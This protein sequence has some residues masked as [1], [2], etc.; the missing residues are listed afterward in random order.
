MSVILGSL[1]G[2]SGADLLS[3]LLSSASVLSPE[4]VPGDL[5]EEETWALP[6]PYVQ[7]MEGLKRK[8]GLG[9]GE[10]RLPLALRPP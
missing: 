5:Q 1:E 6:V 2:C 9:Q 3:F 4:T 10:Q 8:A 7:G